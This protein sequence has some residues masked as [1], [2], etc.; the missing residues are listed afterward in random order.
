MA[1]RMTQGTTQTGTT[2]T[3]RTTKATK[4]QTPSSV[5]QGALSQISLTLIDLPEKPRETWSLR[6]VIEQL[7]APLSIALQR[8]YSYEEIVKILAD[9][10][11]HITASSL[12]R[13]LSI[14]KRTN[15]TAKPR[16]TRTSKRETVQNSAS[17][18]Q[19]EMSQP[20]MIV[21]PPAEL[22]VEM[23]PR[24]RRG[25][26]TTVSTTTVSKASATAKTTRTTQATKTAAKAK[27]TPRTTAARKRTK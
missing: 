10:G 25:R 2:K 5:P 13:Y 23:S 15:S 19:P 24:R 8:G 3:A 9:C 26:T 27:A 1:K 12:K 21:V 17:G 4:K 20:E 14:A 16:R 6:E 18:S 7:Q 11:I 22:V